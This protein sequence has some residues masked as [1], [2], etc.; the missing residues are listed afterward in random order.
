[1]EENGKLTEIKLLYKFPNKI[2]LVFNYN[3][4]FD[5]NPEI[6]GLREKNSKKNIWAHE[7]KSD[8]ENN[9]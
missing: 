8:M 5:G 1:M 2:W 7:R 3:V 4:V 6:V 9:N